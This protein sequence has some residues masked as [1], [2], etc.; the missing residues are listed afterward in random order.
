MP[1]GR[2][3][4]FP[5]ACHHVMNRG[6]DRAPIFVDD[7]DRKRFLIELR[8]AAFA[9]SVHVI[10]YCLMQNH[11]HLLLMT[12]EGG[13]SRMLQ[14]FSS[15]YTQAFN[16]R[17]RRDG[18]LFRGRFRSVVVEDD[19]QLIQTTLYIHRN[20]VE[21]GLAHDAAQWKWSS[22]AALVGTGEMP[23]WLQGDY[24][25]GL[26]GGVDPRRA[27]RELLRGPG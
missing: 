8:G 2:R 7:L 23:D 26:L 3:E 24:V 15:S 6:A 22:A 5:G 16:R 21:A 10:C 20:P 19:A 11:F 12:P 14:R 9:G 4:D 27:Y 25:L 18:P 13:V 17:H 1:R